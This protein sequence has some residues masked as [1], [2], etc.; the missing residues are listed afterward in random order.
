MTDLAQRTSAA[1]ARF[2]EGARTRVVGNLY[3][4][5]A[6]GS[7]KALFDAAASLLERAL[8]PLFDRRFDRRPD[9]GVSVLFFASR[10]AFDAFALER[11]S[12][13]GSG[14]AGLYERSSR[15]I[16]VDLSG[17]AAFLPTLT[18]EI[19]HP[20][21][22]ADF[23]LAPVWLNEAVAS[24]FE[25]P[26]FTQDGGIHGAR[27]TWRYAE[28]K[29]FR[30]VPRT[31][32]LVR[33]DSLFGM[34][35]PTFRGLSEDRQSMDL[36]RGRLHAAVA[37]GFAVWLDEQGLLWPFYRAWRDEVGADPTGEKTFTALLGT[38]LEAANVTW[39]AWVR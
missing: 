22:E 32:A 19:V 10:S 38:S 33:I 12:V 30:A 35:G 4:L 1:T 31:R 37:R 6:P 36:E 28:L 39:L 29:A 15:V 17:G 8:P 34:S 5:A 23:P 3:V 26:V 24:V 13:L 25:A 2:G 7:V 20:I 18:H 14:N 11:S 21:L 9:A 27:E 16:A